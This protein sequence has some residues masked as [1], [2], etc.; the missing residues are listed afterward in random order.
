M[1]YSE[2]TVNMIIILKMWTGKEIMSDD[3]R[4]TKNLKALCAEFMTSENHLNDKDMNFTLTCHH[5]TALMMIL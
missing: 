3:R 5:T 4:M 1:E 2:V